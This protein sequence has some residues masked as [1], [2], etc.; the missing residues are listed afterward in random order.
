MRSAFGLRFNASSVATKS[1]PS[2]PPETMPSPLCISARTSFR[3][4][5]STSAVHH[6]QLPLI[7][8]HSIVFSFCILQCSSTLR[9][10]RATV[11]RTTPISAA[12]NLCGAHANIVQDLLSPSFCLRILIWLCGLREALQQQGTDSVEARA[13]RTFGFAH[14]GYYCEDQREHT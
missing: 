13:K 12:T 8:I 4:S 1:T 14:F 2:A 10:Q 11:W 5:S 7:A 6:R 9:A 3:T